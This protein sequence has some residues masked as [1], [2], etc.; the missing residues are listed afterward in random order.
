[1]LEFSYLTRTSGWVKTMYIEAQSILWKPFIENENFI[2]KLEQIIAYCVHSEMRQ[3]L[4]NLPNVPLDHGYDVNVIFTDDARMRVMNN[5]WR[6]KNSSTNILS[7]AALE[8]IN[9]HA[10]PPEEAIHLG[11]LVLAFET[12]KAEALQASI[13]IETHI[14]RLIIHGMYHLLGYDH[15]SDHDYALM[16]DR[17]RE[18]LEY[19]SI[20]QYIDQL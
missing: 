14:L 19:F 16:F 1:M 6:K 3:G 5:E 20:R 10:L 11:D 12:I 13:D 15:I 7:F 17:E 18:A 2:D 8:G 4:P 9:A